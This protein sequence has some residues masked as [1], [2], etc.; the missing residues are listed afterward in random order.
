MMSLKM[1]T[2]SLICE[3]ANSWRFTPFYL[4]LSLGHF[5][6]GLFSAEIFYRQVVFCRNILLL[7]YFL[8]KHFTARLFLTVC[9]FNRANVSAVGIVYGLLLSVLIQAQGIKYSGFLGSSLIA[10]GPCIK[11][12]IEFQFRPSNPNN[13]HYSYYLQVTL[14]THTT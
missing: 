6:V 5:T 11:P 12:I 2:C 8:Q 14:I 10:F 9:F 13:S 3:I 4:T 7:G 1:Q